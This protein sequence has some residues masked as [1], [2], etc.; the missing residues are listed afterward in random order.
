[1]GKGVLSKIKMIPKVERRI[2]S[3]EVDCIEVP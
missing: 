2:N 3:I 1:M